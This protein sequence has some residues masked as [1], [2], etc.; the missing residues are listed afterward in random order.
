MTAIP[1]RAEPLPTPFE[2]AIS[3]PNDA[4]SAESHFDEQAWAIWP[5]SRNRDRGA[6][7]CSVGSLGWRAAGWRSALVRGP[8]RPRGRGCPNGVVGG[9]RGRTAG[10]DRR[11]LMFGRTRRKEAEAFYRSVIA[12]RRE[13][14]ARGQ[15]ACFGSGST[16]IGALRTIIDMR[17]SATRPR[18]A[19]EASSE[20]EARS[21]IRAGEALDGRRDRRGSTWAC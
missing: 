16:T 12:M 21:A 3:Q 14:Q 17:G 2:E 7:R 1:N 18:P 4:G 9:D 11:W 5:K 20:L 10:V 15:P 19:R 6:A 8:A 13:E